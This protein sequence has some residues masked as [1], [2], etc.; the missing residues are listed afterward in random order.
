M[1][2]TAQLQLEEDDARKALEEVREAAEQT[3]GLVDN[4]N[5]RAALTQKAI[6][7]ITETEVDFLRQRAQKERKRGQKSL[8]RRHDGV[9]SIL[10][11]VKINERVTGSSFER[12]FP[13]IENGIHVI[14]KRGE[15]FLGANAAEKINQTI[16]EKISEMENSVAADLAGVRTQLEMAQR[17]NFIQ[18]TYISPASEHQVQVRSRLGKRVLDA[19][20]L[21]DEV[22]CGLQ[23]LAWN[24]EVEEVQIDAQEV[25][26]KKSVKELAKFI[27]RTLRGMRSKVEPKDETISEREYS[28]SAA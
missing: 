17:T 11:T 19:L 24:G 23:T 3:A 27:A 10:L 9:A 1:N 12:F 15:M 26:I 25:R 7:A 6:K 16:L 5:E 13:I 14:A 2:Q 18:P 20:I 28:S 22:L 21:Q 4:G 8:A